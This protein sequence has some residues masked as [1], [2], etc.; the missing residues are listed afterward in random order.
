MAQN[1]VGRALK[2]ALTEEQAARLAEYAAQLPELADE[3]GEPEGA[4]SPS[5]QGE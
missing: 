1:R 2:A 4:V 5:G 3:L